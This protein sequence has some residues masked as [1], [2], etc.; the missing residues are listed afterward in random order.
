MPISIPL[1]KTPTALLVDVDFYDNAEKAAFQ[2]RGLRLPKVPIKIPFSDFCAFYLYYKKQPDVAGYRSHD[3]LA[4]KWY[5]AAVELEGL[6]T[7]RANSMQAA[8]TTATSRGTTERIGEAI[9]LGVITAI[10]KL[11]QGDWQRIPESNVQKS[12]DFEQPFASTGTQLIQLEA[13]G[14]VTEDN[15]LKSSSISNLKKSIKNKKGDLKVVRSSGIFYGTVTVISERPDSRIKCWLIDPPP[16]AEGNPAQVKVLSR[17][18]YISDLISYLG[19]RSNLASALQ[20][21][22][23]SL[24]ALASIDAL[25]N[26]PL[27]RGNSREFPDQIYN[28]VT[29]NRNSWFAGKS[30]ISNVAGGG[31]V[32]RAG[33]AILFLGVME[34]LINM[35]ARQDFS[36]IESYEFESQSVDGRVDCVVS[37]GRFNSDFA[38]MFPSPTFLREGS[39]VRFTAEGKLNY[40]KSG[41]VFGFVRPT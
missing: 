20:T 5:Q 18:K 19:S 36:E 32:L 38:D 21:R 7:F 13:K 4:N 9:G 29:R 31:Q 33:D 37:A 34:N 16:Y 40:T 10:H 1:P 15:N 14:S 27:R 12:L 6:V 25:D 17:L 35:V 26:V 28:P 3:E 8:S 23:A 30:V 11:H 39:Y 22:I 2:Q 41:L 24:Q